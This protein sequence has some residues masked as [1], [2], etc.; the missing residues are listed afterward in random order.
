LLWGGTEGFAMS[1][2]E[3]IL[4]YKAAMAVFK[5]WLADGVI[6]ETDLLAID[7]MLADKYGLSSCSI[8]LEN[9]LLCKENRVIYSGTKG[10]CY[11]QKNN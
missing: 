4:R 7:T 11:G 6:T 8:F 10:G 3:A 9:D 5:N 1:K 2:Q